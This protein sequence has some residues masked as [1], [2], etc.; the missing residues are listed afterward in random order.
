MARADRRQA[1]RQARRVERRPRAAGGG[2][3]I[4]Q[5]WVSVGPVETSVVVLPTRSYTSALV[6]R[7]SGTSLSLLSKMT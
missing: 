7:S 5:E 2:T 4:G 1:T 6:S 3:Q